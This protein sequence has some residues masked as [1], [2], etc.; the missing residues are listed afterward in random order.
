M[1]LQGLEPDVVGTFKQGPPCL[2]TLDMLGIPEGGRN[3]GLFNIGIYF[4][5]SDPDNWEAKLREYNRSGKIDPPLKDADMKSIIRSLASKDYQYKCDDIPINAHCEKAKC[6]KERYG[7][8]GFRTAKLNGSMPKLENLRK[9]LTDPPRWTLTINEQ[10]VDLQTDDLMLIPR[11]RRCV[12]E[13]C[14]IVFPVMKQHEWDHHLETLLADHTIVEAPED[15]GVSGMF[16]YLFREFLA[17]RRN[18]RNRE[19]LL[20]GLPYLE[21]GKVFFRSM[22][23]LAFLERKKFRDYDTSDVFIALRKLGA[24]HVKWNVKG[25]GLQLWYIEEPKDD[26]DEPFDAVVD[27]SP[28]F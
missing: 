13:R 1:H 28:E 2:N 23:L 21:S 25:Q 7:I 6:K 20:S 10:D 11:L 19:D 15:A 3:M 16:R 24:G 18:A 14:S 12:M 17:R 22:D 9:I 26:Q 4:K 8:S 27:E 5:L